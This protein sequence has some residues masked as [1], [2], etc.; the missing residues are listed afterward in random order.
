MVTLMISF[1]YPSSVGLKMHNE[2][3][4][5]YQKAAFD[6]LTALDPNPNDQYAP[7]YVFYV[8]YVHTYVYMYTYVC[9]MNMHL[10]MCFM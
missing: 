3:S 10:T 1:T 4:H 6:Y 8:R 2:F 9:M 7:D 5:L